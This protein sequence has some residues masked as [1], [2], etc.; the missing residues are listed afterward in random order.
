MT[1][2]LRKWITLIPILGLLIIFGGMQTAAAEQTLVVGRGSD[3]NS[4]D[5]A[6]ATS[7]EAIK[8][9]DWSFDGL[10]KFDGNSHKIVPALAESWKISDDGLT[11]TF[12]LK[13]GV[14]FHHHDGEE[15]EEILPKEAQDTENKGKIIE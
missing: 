10:V 2:R 8:C 4:L 13:K 1:S 3:A 9:A 11:W 12:K 7:F 14:K 15:Q 5:P 6:E